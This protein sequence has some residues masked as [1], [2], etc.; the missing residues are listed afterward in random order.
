[1]RRR[2]G[3][4]G[5]DGAAT[6]DGRRARRGRP[7]EATGG[8]GTTGRG[9]WRRLGQKWGGEERRVRGSGLLAGERR[10]KT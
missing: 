9:D 4:R 5:V 6:A 8:E 3:A 10:N 7:D 2:L 1:M